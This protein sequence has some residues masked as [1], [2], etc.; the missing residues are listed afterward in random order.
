MYYIVQQA[1]LTHPRTHTH[2]EDFLSVHEVM[3]YLGGAYRSDTKYK[4]S[5]V[6]ILQGLP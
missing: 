1:P 4:Q 5:H 3:G 2:T 6:V